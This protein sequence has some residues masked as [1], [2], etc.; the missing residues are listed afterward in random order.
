MKGKIVIAIGLLLVLFC[1]KVLAIEPIGTEAIDYLETS[2]FSLAGNR[3]LEFDPSTPYDETDI[4]LVRLLYSE[5]SNV[6]IFQV[7]SNPITYDHTFVNNTKNYGFFVD[8]ATDRFVVSVDYSSIEVPDSIEDLINQ[9]L[10]EKN[11]YIEQL[12][13]QIMGLEDEVD[14]LNATID[15]NE[16]KIAEL[17]AT[18]AILLAERNKAVEDKDNITV[19]KYDVEQNLSIYR[20]RTN[21]LIVEKSEKEKRIIYLQSRIN[22]ATDPWAASIEIDGEIR[23]TLNW[24]SFL[25]GI[26]CCVGFL[27]V[28]RRKLGLVHEGNKLSIFVNG[29]KQRMPSK[30]QRTT[31]TVPPTVSDDIKEIDDKLMKEG[32]TREMPSH[33]E[34]EPKPEPEPEPKEEKKPKP[35]IQTVGDMKIRFVRKRMDAGLKANEAEEEWREQLNKLIGE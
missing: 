3:S 27:Y 7:T 31:G 22:D 33:S 16:A 28:F 29:I 14:S 17:E 10:E 24:I 5:I 19:E 11:A 2:L 25:V 32:I 4:T 34:P 35:K 20:N 6:T 15:S 23:S 13:F 9:S 21:S 8:G 1:P 26:L 30:R 18:A 12:L